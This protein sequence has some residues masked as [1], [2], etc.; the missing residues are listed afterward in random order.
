MVFGFN[1]AATHD[2]C[3]DTRR[4][5]LAAL[6]NAHKAYN[7]EKAR[8]L[9]HSAIGWWFQ[10]KGFER[11]SRDEKLEEKLARIVFVTVH[12]YPADGGITCRDRITTFEA[13][14]KPH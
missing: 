14:S 12:L 1:G 8:E 3:N 13:P 5:F 6:M 2:T 11:K 9:A 7:E 4:S 10:H